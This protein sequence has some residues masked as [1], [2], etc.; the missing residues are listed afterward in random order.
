MN[1]FLERTFDATPFLSNA[2]FAVKRT[3]NTL[4]THDPAEGRALARIA[5]GRTDIHTGQ[6]GTKNPTGPQQYI[7]YGQ[8]KDIDHAVKQLGQKNIFVK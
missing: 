1:K 7:L 6:S 8:P 3:G 5:F 4:F 2:R